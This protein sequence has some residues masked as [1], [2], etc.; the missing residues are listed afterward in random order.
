MSRAGGN[1]TPLHRSWAE[2]C[3]NWPNLGGFPRTYALRHL[4]MHLLEVAKTEMS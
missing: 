1:L 3:M 4:P 2:Y